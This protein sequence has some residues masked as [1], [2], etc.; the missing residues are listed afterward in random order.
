MKQSVRV[1]GAPG[2]LAGEEESVQSRY[3]IMEKV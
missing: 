1:T 2:A 3:K